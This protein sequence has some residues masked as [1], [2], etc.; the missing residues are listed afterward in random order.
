MNPP[1]KKQNAPVIVGQEARSRICRRLPMH[2]H[3]VWDDRNRVCQGKRPDGV[4]LTFVESVND[5]GAFQM[6]S[7]KSRKCH[8]L[9]PGRV[10]HGPCIEHAVGRYDNRAGGTSMPV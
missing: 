9:F 8:T 3:A 1:E 2:V 7:L 4:S 6:I 10:A 5:R